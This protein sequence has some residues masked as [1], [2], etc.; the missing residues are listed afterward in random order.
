MGHNYLICY[1]NDASQVST[2]NDE[3]VVRGTNHGRFVGRTIGFGWLPGTGHAIGGRGADHNVMVVSF[4]PHFFDW[5]SGCPC[6]AKV[7]VA[8]K[9]RDKNGWRGLR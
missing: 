7:E 6:K 4:L 2:K 3:V 8:V 9:K 1:Q 5:S